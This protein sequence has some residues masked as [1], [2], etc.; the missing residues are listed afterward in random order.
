MGS[1][2]HLAA[3]LHATGEEAFNARHWAELVREAERGTLDFVTFGDS[4]GGR[5]GLDAVLTAA[6]AWHG[7]FSSCCRRKRRG[8]AT[9]A[10]A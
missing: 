1:R 3:A 5:P 9:G 6:R 4:L 2:L 7:G 8:S 10:S